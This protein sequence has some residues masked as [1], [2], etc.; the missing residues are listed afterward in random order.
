MEHENKPASAIPDE[1]HDSFAHE[2][3]LNIEM[4]DLERL[5]QGGNGLRQIVIDDFRLLQGIGGGGALNMQLNCRLAG[6]V[7][8]CLARVEGFT[9]RR[10]IAQQDFLA[11][12]CRAQFDR[13][14]LIGGLGKP[15]AAKLLLEPALDG[16]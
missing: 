12:A 14:D 1:Q 16:A 10:D 3:C 8:G 13:A 4:H 2:T 9:D 15:Q 6:A 5:R 11:T 7:T